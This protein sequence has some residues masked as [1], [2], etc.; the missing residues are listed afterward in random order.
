MRILSLLP[1]AT[2]IVAALGFESRLVGRSHECDFPPGVRRLPVCTAPKIDV[3]GRSDEI[4]RDI[5][6][7]LAMT[8]SVYRVDA[9]RLRDLSPTH[10]VTQV[11]CEVCAVSLGEVEDALEDWS[12]PKPRLIALS[13]RDLED[14][15]RDVE[16]VAEALD[17]PERGRS[18]VADLRRRMEV[19]ARRVREGASS[20]PRVAA[21]EWLSPLMAAGNWIPEMVAMAGGENLF[22]ET[23][24]HSPWL[25]WEDLKASDPDVMILLPCGFSLERVRAE[26]GLLSVLPG[27]E[28]LSAVRTGRVYLADGNQYFNRPGPRLVESLETLGQIL[29]PEV[30]A[31]T[32]EGIAWERLPVAGTRSAG[33]SSEQRFEGGHR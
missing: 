32:L 22:G 27:W 17:A 9:A 23:G 5:Q 31:G 26:L 13:S 11:Q 16:R 4:H 33:S 2:E 6:R 21:I 7:I 30:F 18:L 20:C 3:S 28:T 8:L 29:H 1:S 25:S 19:I 10:V 12:T 24:V 15:F 14:V